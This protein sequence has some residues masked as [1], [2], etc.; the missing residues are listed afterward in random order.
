MPKTI[1][2]WSIASTYF[3][4]FSVFGRMVRPRLLRMLRLSTSAG[5][6]C[7]SVR[8]MPMERS[9]VSAVSP[10]PVRTMATSS[11]SSRSTSATSAG[12]PVTVSWLPRAWTAASNA[13]STMRRYSSPGP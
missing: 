10:W 13:S 3:F 5:R 11:S 6:S 12:A 1:V 4:W 8:S 2:F 9:T 7:V